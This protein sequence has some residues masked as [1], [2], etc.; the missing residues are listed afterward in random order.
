MPRSRGSP[1]MD[2]SFLCPSCKSAL[3]RSA[4]LSPGTAVKCPRCQ[5]VF[6]V[7]AEEEIPFAPIIPEAVA[8]RPAPPPA[9]APRRSSRGPSRD[10]DFDDDREYGDRGRAGRRREE[11]NLT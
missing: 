6:E 11:V 2:D 8:E 1:A 5:H 9:P 4:Q 10:F 7:P 3:R